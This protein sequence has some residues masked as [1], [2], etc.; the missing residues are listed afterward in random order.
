MLILRLAIGVI[1]KQLL[2]AN[3]YA[4]YSKISTTDKTCLAKIYSKGIESRGLSSDHRKRGWI[5][6][7]LGRVASCYGEKR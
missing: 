2:A 6:W 5:F 3:N 1:P 4:H 7:N